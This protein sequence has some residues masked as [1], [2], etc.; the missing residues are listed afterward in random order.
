[1]RKIFFIIARLSLWGT[2]FCHDNLN[3]AVC[4]ADC[5]FSTKSESRIKRLSP[6]K[7]RDLC[8]LSSGINNGMSRRSRIRCWSSGSRIHPAAAW[9]FH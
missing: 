5:R 1:M 3:R 8:W 9:L 7:P 4:V 2:E 6:E